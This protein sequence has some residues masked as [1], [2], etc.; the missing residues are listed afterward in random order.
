MYQVLHLVCKQWLCG[1]RWL[2]HKPKRMLEI[3]AAVSW[4][5]AVPGTISAGIL[6]FT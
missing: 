1:L 4:I 2:S 5:V 3:Q 6:K